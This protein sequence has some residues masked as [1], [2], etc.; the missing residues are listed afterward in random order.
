MII[1]ELVQSLAIAGMVTCISLAVGFFIDSIMSGWPV[2][3]MSIFVFFIALESIYAERL[4][5]LREVGQRD[6]TRFRI[7]E[8]IVILLA[9]RFGIYFSLGWE[10]LL[11]DAAMWNKDAA[12][13]FSPGFQMSALFTLVYWWLARY[14]SKSI[15]ELKSDRAEL[16]VR[17]T[18]PDFYL[19]ST[20]PRKGRVDRLSRIQGFTTV[21]FLGGVLM[22][23][24]AGLSQMDV[25]YL[26]FK[27]L[28]SPKVGVNILVYFL[29]GLLLVSQI[30]YTTL[31]ALWTIQGIPITSR[32]GR[33][34][35]ASLIAFLVIAGILARL[36]P[37]DYSVGIISIIS[38]VVRWVAYAVLYAIYL[39]IAGV[40]YLFMWVVSFF[41]STPTQTMIPPTPMPTPEPPPLTADPTQTASWVQIAKSLFF[42]VLLVGVGGYALLHF[43]NDRMDLFRRLR[44]LRLFRWLASFL[45]GLGRRTA[46]L[47][48]VLQRTVRKQADALASAVKPKPRMRA[49]KWK[50]MSERE[51]LRF[52]YLALLESARE[53]GIARPDAATPFEFEPELA[54]ALT[55]AA[56]PA[57]NLTRGFVLARYTEHPVDSSLVEAAR[58]DWSA[59]KRALNARKRRLAEQRALD[60]ETQKR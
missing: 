47:W 43:L 29:L 9:L 16:P 33:R 35:V 12:S 24:L 48:R 59:A 26:E 55:D 42:W 19:R 50:E 57:A 39:I 40:T 6:A 45:S 13:F 21:F 15:Q 1:E 51:R 25:R 28:P 58:M 38:T 7:V 17:V 41:K 14:M 8:W 32:L 23:A 27:S 34:W 46:D 36:M 44:A 10:R 5:Q 22:I 54:A 60:A 20:L 31:K 4:L 30:H 53:Q 2:R 37:V 11:T 18:D 56:G 49:A 3:F 52:L